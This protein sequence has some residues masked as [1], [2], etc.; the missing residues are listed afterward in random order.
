MNGFT[1]HSNLNEVDF[2]ESK[3]MSMKT[4]DAFRKDHIT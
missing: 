1:N 4:F 2:E 3:G